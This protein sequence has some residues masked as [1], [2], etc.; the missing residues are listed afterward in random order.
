ME[1]Q[2]LN[3]QIKQLERELGFALLARRENRTLLTAAGTAF[4][5]DA[6]GVLSAADRAVEHA[7]AVARGEAGVLR[8]GYVTPMTHA[9]LA[10]AIKE[11]HEAHPDVSFDL[12]ALRLSEQERALNRHELELGFA[13]LPVPDDNFDALAIHSMKVSIAA[14]SGS[15]LAG[16]ERI[17]WEDLDGREVISLE[18]PFPEYQ[19]RIDA[20]LAERGV[21]VRVVQHADD[22]ESALALV[23]VGLGIAVVP[24]V[25][26][27]LSRDLSFV[28][29]PDDAADMEIAAIWRRDHD[30]PL[31]DRFLQLLA[32]QT[33]GEPVA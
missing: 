8:I 26:H 30:S 12:H 33:K 19:H 27:A 11:F 6:E 24:N 21:R 4:L 2:P 15:T 16:R 17:D 22:I 29:L 7:A 25:N 28:A 13:V 20:M 3:F 23:N 9:F 1:P 14:S 18:R 31:R 32:E 5:A 10:P